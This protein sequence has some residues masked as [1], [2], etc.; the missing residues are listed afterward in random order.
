MKKLL[1]VMP[2]I[3]ALGGCSDPHNTVIPKDLSKWESVMKQPLEKLN[4][5]EKDQLAKYYMRHALGSVFG[6]QKEMP[7][8]TTIKQALAEQQ[9]VDLQEKKK[10]AEA[11]A[12]KQKLDKERLQ[13][14]KQFNDAI[15]VA[16]LSKK[17]KEGEYSF[18]NS[19][20]I[21]IGFENK[22]SKDI[23]GIKGVAVFTDIFGEKIS[24]N[25]IEYDK[26]IPAGKTVTF[27][28]DVNKMADGFYKLKDTDF[29][30]I[31][32]NFDPEQVIFAD[33]TKLSVAKTE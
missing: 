31:K 1:L 20:N 19:L 17:Y 15:T 11:A 6:N 30:K 9:E 28:G 8:G 2:F 3:I 27:N 5:T 25:L 13:L 7:E 24:T 29:E 18:M 22:S 4:A 12:L 10:E 16:F 32:F 23:T 14:K 33:G 21:S 26:T